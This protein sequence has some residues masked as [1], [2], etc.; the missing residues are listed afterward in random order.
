MARPEK[1]GIPYFSFDVD[2]FSDIKVKKIMRACGPKSIPVLINLLCNIYRDKG[3]YIE[4]DDEIGFLVADEVG[5][6]ESIAEEVVNK[7]L[8]V[9]FFDKGIFEKYKILTSKGIQKRYQK[10]TYQ[11]KN[12]AIN[13]DLLIL[14]HEKHMNNSVNHIESTQSKEKQSKVNKSKA[15]NTDVLF[16]HFLQI[17]SD[18]TKGVKSQPRS[19]ASAAFVDLGT[20]ERRQQ[21]II[22]AKNYVTWYKSTGEGIKYSINAAKFLEDMTFMDYQEVPMVKEKSNSYSKAGKAI[23]DWATPYQEPEYS[24]EEIADVF[25]D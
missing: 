13:P 9:G 24:E 20:E 14:E 10:A 7:S 4:W 22:G 2:F 15:N 3:Y 1:Q 6:N 5:T 21:A 11:R 16:E 12:N 18:F 25:K 17:F 23:P 8:Q 19:R